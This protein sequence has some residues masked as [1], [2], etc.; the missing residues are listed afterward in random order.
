MSEQ[1]IKLYIDARFDHMNGEI[2]KAL[3][4]YQIISDSTCEQSFCLISKLLIKQ[5][6]MSVFN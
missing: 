6:E 1:L 2:D 4:K 5:S 3:K